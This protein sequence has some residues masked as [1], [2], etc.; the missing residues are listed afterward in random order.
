MPSKLSKA[1]IHFCHSR[2]K[3]LMKTVFSV[4]VYGIILSYILK[5]ERECKECSGGWMRDTLKYGAVAFLLISTLGLIPAFCTLLNENVMILSV[6]GLAKIFYLVVLIT[7]IWKIKRDPDCQRCSD[8]WRRLGIEVYVYIFAAML[9]I[10]FLYPF[11][12]LAM[13]SSC[14]LCKDKK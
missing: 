10:A 12:V 11:V 8:D 4:V 7:Y 2:A 3:T 1:T 14:K 9:L 13:Y 6:L 5:L